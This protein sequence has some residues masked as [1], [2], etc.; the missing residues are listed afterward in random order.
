MRINISNSWV[1]FE[2]FYNYIS[3]I[4]VKGI[5]NEYILLKNILTYWEAHLWDDWTFFDECR[6]IYWINYEV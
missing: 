5:S 2:L 3:P 6:P 4:H 1:Q